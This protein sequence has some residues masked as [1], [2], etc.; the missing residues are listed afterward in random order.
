MIDLNSNNIY[1]TF[2]P[3]HFVLKIFG[4]AAYQLDLNKSRAIKISKNRIY[5]FICCLFYIGLLIFNLYWGEQ[6]PDAEVSLLIRH[7]WHKLR[8]IQIMCMTIIT[9]INYKN[10]D[11]TIKCLELINTFDKMKTFSI[12]HSSN[13]S[14]HRKICMFVIVGYVIYWSIICPTTVLLYNTDE[15]DYIHFISFASYI[16]C[17]QMAAIIGYQFI[18]FT[19]C[20]KNRFEVLLK[21][22]EENFC[23][24]S[25]K[26]MLLNTEL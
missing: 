10:Q 2:A 14:K 12:N 20:L 6:E 4:L 23:F 11:I 24:V 5:I 7:G 25:R 22:I 16:L 15:L 19:G 9:I 3:L 13:H 17:S 21:N 26:E 1:Q 18:F 8:L